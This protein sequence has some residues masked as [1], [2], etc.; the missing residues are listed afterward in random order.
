MKNLLPKIIVIIA[1]MIFWLLIVAGQNYV[2][3]TEIPLRVYEPRSD[4]TL[5]KV[6]PEKGE[7]SCGRART[8]SLFSKM[9]QK[10]FSCA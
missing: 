5:G 10:L 8:Y 1:A 2:V 3:V 6:L 7:R 9:V 4:M